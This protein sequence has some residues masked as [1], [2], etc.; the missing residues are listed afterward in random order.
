MAPTPVP[1]IRNATAIATGFDFACALL[2]GGLVQC[3]GSN[4]YG[5][6]GIGDNSNPI[7][8]L[9]DSKHQLQFVTALAAGDSHVRALQHI[10]GAS[11]NVYCWG[12]N[13]FG[14][15]GN[16]ADS[17]MSRYA[18]PV[19]VHDGV[20]NPALD[21]VESISEG[22]LFGCAQRSDGTVA[23]WGLNSFGQLGDGS[24][25][26][27]VTP[28]YVSNS[29]GTVSFLGDSLAAGGNHACALSAG[30]GST[31]S[32]E[33]WGSNLDGELGNSFNALTGS[34]VTRPV[35]VQ[36]SIGTELTGVAAVASRGNFTCALLNDLASVDCWGANDFG[37]LGNR[38]TAGSVQPVSAFFRGV[39]LIT[40]LTA[41][42]HHACALVDGE[43]TCWGANDFG[44][45]GLGYS[46]ADAHSSPI[47][48]DVDAP[49]FNA[50]FE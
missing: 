4:E 42:S 11:S 13:E 12:S 9:R 22:E 27:T 34:A 1:S 47:V 3:W 19:I 41:G 32:V 48:V 23:C 36:F 15:L 26:S 29:N 35:A 40:S 30:P 25:Q 44:Q 24:I 16:F 38:T 18:T 17:S 43:V 2:E 14:Q 20:T 45:L 28:D 10:V 50:D 5:Q 6:L 49:I 39:S 37:Q 8:V 21:Q 33:C 46:D 7:P 31:D